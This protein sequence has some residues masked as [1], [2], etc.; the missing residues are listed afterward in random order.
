MDLYRK[1]YNGWNKAKQVTCENINVN[2]ARCVGVKVV[3]NKYIL[4]IE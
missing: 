4:F 3:L 1:I 2:K